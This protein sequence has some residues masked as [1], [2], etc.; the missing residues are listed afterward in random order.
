MESW[1]LCSG[2]SECVVLKY[3]KL[4]D[5]VFVLASIVSAFCPWYVAQCASVWRE[6]LLNV[7]FVLAADIVG[8]VN[9]W[10]LICTS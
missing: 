1:S 4:V 9:A 8:H 3:A 10:L 2:S 7:R 6:V 5:G